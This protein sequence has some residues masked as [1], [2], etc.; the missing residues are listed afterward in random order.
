MSPV[1]Q[2]SLCNELITCHLYLRV[3]FTP[4]RIT[5]HCEQHVIA[6]SEK[7]SEGKGERDLRQLWAGFRGVTTLASAYFRH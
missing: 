2:A 6:A 7:T 3:L 1:P 5:R 4:F